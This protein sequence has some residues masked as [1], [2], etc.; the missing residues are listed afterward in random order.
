VSA[1]LPR[2]AKPIVPRC[3]SMSFQF[4][5]RMDK[6]TTYTYVTLGCN[7]PYTTQTPRYAQVSLVRKATRLLAVVRRE[8][9]YFHGLIA[10]SSSS[11]QAKPR[12]ERRFLPSIGQNSLDQPGQILFNNI[13][14]VRNCRGDLR[15]ADG[16]RMMV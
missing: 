6:E 2:K 13:A 14:W 9:P 11:N 12:A 4:H 15:V 7:T 10:S 1:R 8:I 5:T 3:S 16:R